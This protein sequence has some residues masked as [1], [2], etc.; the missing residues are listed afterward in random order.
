MKLISLNIWGGR[1]YSELIEFVEHYRD[2]VD[3]FVFQEVYNTPTK[4]KYTR[5]TSTFQ[6]PFSNVFP[7][8]AT[9]YHDLLEKLPNHTSYFESAQD[10]F[11]YLG[12]VDFELSFGLA[13]FVNKK[14]TISEYQSIFVFRD[15]NS[16]INRDNASMGRNIQIF[17]INNGITIINFHGLWN[18]L[19]KIDCP[20]RIEQSKNIRKVL[21]T[22]AYPKILAGDYNLN[23]NTESLKMLEKDMVNL[24]K[25]NNITSTR[26]S[27]YEKE[28]KF[29]D[30]I[31]VS[32][33]ITI[34]D[35]KV[36]SDTVSDHSPLYLEFDNEK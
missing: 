16:L 31:L 34:K 22:A 19:Q 18:T 20:E 30:Y 32:P 33:E 36:L 29:A 4:N 3:I 28:N 5:D 26:S 1:V 6:S 9:I 35:F 27:L 23:P 17:T 13:S 12:K 25:K 10:N 7:P 8:R 15:K 14:H 24:I 2:T 11:D 21:D